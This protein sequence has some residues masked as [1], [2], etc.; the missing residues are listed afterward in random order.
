MEVWDNNIHLSSSL[1]G[2]LLLPDADSVGISIS[3]GRED[4]EVR[5]F[6]DLGFVGVDS[7]TWEAGSSASSFSISTIC[8][9]PCGS[10]VDLRGLALLVLGASVRDGGLSV[11]VPSDEFSVEDSERQQKILMRKDFLKILLCL[12]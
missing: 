9:S 1:L 7:S 11:S 6:R 5:A 10:F 12:R 2:T 3:I 4:G 8:T